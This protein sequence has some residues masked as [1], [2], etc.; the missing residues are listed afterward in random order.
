[1]LVAALC[2]L[3]L[4][5]R[6]SSATV[7]ERIVAIVGERAILMSDLRDALGRCCRE[8]IK[9]YPLGPNVPRQ[10]HNSTSP[11]VERLVDE[12]LIVRIAKSRRFNIFR[13]GCRQRACNLGSQNNITI[14]RLLLESRAQGQTD[15]KYREEIR[16]QLLEYRVMNVRLQGAFKSAMKTC[17]ARTGRLSCKSARIS[18]SRRH[19]YSFDRRLRVCP[20]RIWPIRSC[21]LAR[22]PRFRGIGS[23]LFD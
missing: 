22:R 10:S 15:A 9:S 3:R 13:E 18:A 8:S 16:R 23:A 5:S 21:G 2:L 20:Q 1:V 17:A 12:E 11:V 6:N 14:E 19:G 4:P 7:V